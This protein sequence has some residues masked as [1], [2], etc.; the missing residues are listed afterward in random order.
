M[1]HH[2]HE[3]DE[4]W[5]KEETYTKSTVVKMVDEAQKQ[6]L[7]NA[8]YDDL[9]KEVEKRHQMYHDALVNVPSD[10][11]RRELKKREEDSMKPKLL[12]EEE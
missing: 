5:R 1:S 4:D 7:S 8:S 3:E 6:A 11:L 2:Y 12:V 9:M 10:V